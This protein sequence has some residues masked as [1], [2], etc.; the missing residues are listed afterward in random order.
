MCDYSLHALASR[1]AEVGETLV[2]AKFPG[3]STRGLASEAEPGVAV[4]ILPG[5]EL[6]FAKRCPI[7]QPLDMDQ[8]HP[9]PRR[10][11][12]RDRAGCSASPP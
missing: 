5:T 7:R 12:W 11:I 8:D 3:T 4:C 6:A 1:P 10:K 2:T 9:L